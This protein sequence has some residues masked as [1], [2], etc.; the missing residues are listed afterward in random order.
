MYR[1][2]TRDRRRPRCRAS[3]SASPGGSTSAP[4][5]DL[6][7]TDPDTGGC[8]PRGW[9]PGEFWGGLWERGAWDSKVSQ[10]GTIK[11]LK[12]GETTEWNVEERGSG[13]GA[14]GRRF[15]DRRHKTS[16]NAVRW[17]ICGELMMW[18]DR[19]STV[20]VG[21]NDDVHDDPN[22]QSRYPR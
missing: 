20:V 15:Q 1:W 22:Y 8:T 13:G 11:G 7:W 19:T 18:K 10:I 17:M 16:L 12:E 14:R 6:G 5:G 4:A 9:M 2:E 3:A 21:A